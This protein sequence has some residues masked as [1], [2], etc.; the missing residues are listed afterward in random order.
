MLKNIMNCI[1]ND[2]DDNYFYT[3]IA[4]QF[5]NDLIHYDKAKVCQV[6]GQN[7]FEYFSKETFFKTSLTKLRNWK[8]II[9]NY[10]DINKD[11]INI[12]IKQMDGIFS[13][14]NDSVIVKKLRRISFVIYSSKKDTFEKNFNSIKELIK[15]FFTDYNNSNEIEKELFLMLRILFL[16]FNH[17]NIMEMIRSFWPIIFNELVNNLEKKNKENTKINNEK[18]ELK[19]ESYKFIE[20]LSLANIEEFSLYQWIFIID[21]FD[22]ERLNF[23]K[24]DS[25]LQIILNQPLIFRPFSIDCCLFW[26]DCENYMISNKKAKSKLVINIDYNNKKDMLEGL[27]GKIKKFFFSIG[28][29]NNYKGDVDENNIEEVIEKD[30]IETIDNQ[31]TKK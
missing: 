5:L 16:R 24:K 22:L 29:M 11:I 10:S 8:E 9:A 13:K 28:D 14:K 25:L 12:L 3:E 23:Q 17:D 6:S 15:E 2:N 27:D 21:T 30:F 18:E 26:N 7:I 31:K 20:L 4:T 1:E 19:L